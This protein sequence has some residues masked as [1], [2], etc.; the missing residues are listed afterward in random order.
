MSDAQWTAEAQNWDSWDFL[1]TISIKFLA[2]K[3]LFIIQIQ[4]IME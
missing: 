4:T 3:F 1:V 2:Q